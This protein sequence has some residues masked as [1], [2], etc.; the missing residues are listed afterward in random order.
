MGLSQ[1]SHKGGIMRGKES[2]QLMIEMA[3]DEIA[4]SGFKEAMQKGD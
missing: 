4:G 3:E 1:L 2:A